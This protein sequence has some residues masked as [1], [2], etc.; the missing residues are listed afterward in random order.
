MDIEMEG[1]DCS[2]SKEHPQQATR[3]FLATTQLT[4]NFNS[5]FIP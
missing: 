1:K 3:T 4:G 2:H 5:L